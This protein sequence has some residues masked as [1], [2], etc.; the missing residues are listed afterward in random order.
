VGSKAPTDESIESIQYLGDYKATSRPGLL[1]MPP[2]GSEWEPSSLKSSPREQR[3]GRK[4]RDQSLQGVFHQAGSSEESTE[5]LSPEQILEQ[6]QRAQEVIGE[7]D[8]GFVD[9]VKRFGDEK[10]ADKIL[11]EL[12]KGEEQA[13]A[14][15]NRSRSGEK[16]N[17]TGN[18]KIAVGKSQAG[19]S[20]VAQA[21]ERLVEHLDKSEQMNQKKDEALLAGI[22]GI[23]AEVPNEIAY[24][25]GRR[26]RTNVV[27]DVNWRRSSYVY[28]KNAEP[29]RRQAINTQNRYGVLTGG[30]EAL[31]QG[32]TLNLQDAQAN[33]LQAT[34]TTIKND[35]TQASELDEWVLGNANDNLA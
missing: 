16:G 8:K 34:P 7:Q 9:K 11:S 28:E 3:K 20:E 24:A 12:L 2:F 17:T 13:K 21:L 35:R 10:S 5:P 33:A 18:Q 22:A 15:Q 29:K 1:D 4:Q 6:I 31:R 26:K 32:K 19:Q 23:M 25:L 30:V 14:A 27:T